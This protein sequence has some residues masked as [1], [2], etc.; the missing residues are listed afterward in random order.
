MEA[1]DIYFQQVAKG[2]E[3]CNLYDPITYILSQGGK[4]V[5]PNLVL[6]S[7]EM[8]GE[9]AEKAFHVA[10]AFEM[11]HNFT[12]IHDD[13]M[14]D[15]PIRRGQPTVYKQWNGNI[16]I[17]AGD[18][19]AI[20]AMQELLKVPTDNATIIK[21]SDLFAQTSLEICEGQQYDLDFERKEN[22]SIEDYIKMIRLKTAVMLAGCLKSSAIL[23][24]ASEQD[25][26]AIYDFGINI[27]LAFQ[28]QDDI[29]DLYSDVE[30]FGKACG[31]DIRENKKT[32]LYLT[33][34]RDADAEQKKQLLHYFS[35]TDF[36]FEEKVSAVKAIYES[37]GVKRKTELAIN[38]YV[39]Q[40]KELLKSISVKEEK[41]QSLYQLA[42]I[43]AHREK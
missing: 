12:L 20:M 4:R 13:I 2:K 26:Q 21:I 22:V 19:L 23:A 27:G 6:L 8:F 32:Y 7:A 34:L 43:L 31:G 11:L 37:L 10:T 9:N 16:A 38:Q 42:D 3:P 24:H 35:S 5:R 14:D 30:V 33:A 39:N 25:Q 15:A 29:L 18:A 1:L 17:L 41:K 40:A 36:D 28:L